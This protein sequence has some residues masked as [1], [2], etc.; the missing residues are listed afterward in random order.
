MLQGL[1]A[2]CEEE[3]IRAIILEQGDIGLDNVRIARDR[4]T[5][6]SRG[7]AFVRFL[8]LQSAQEFMRN[9][10]PSIK[11]GQSWARLAYSNNP[12]GRDQRKQGGSGFNGHPSDRPNWYPAPH[13]YNTYNPMEHQA[14]PMNVGTR[15]IG[16]VPN[17]MLII[18]D[19]PPM[20]NESHVWNSLKLLGP[21]KRVMMV[22]DR[23]SRISWGFCFAE[24]EDIK[25]ATS[26]LESTTTSPLRIQTKPVTIHYAHH[27]SFIPA[28]A[29][30]QWT[31]DF[32]SESQLAMYWDEQAFLS[33]YSELASGIPPERPV[34]KDTTARKVDELDAFYA[35]MG[36]VLKTEPAPGNSV[37]SASTL[38]S[39]PD[40]TTETPVQSSLPAP[41]LP[42]LP[43][44]AK[45]DKDQLAGIAAAQA[46]EQ[47]AKTEE[48]RKR[49]AAS[50]TSTVGIAGGG[51]KISK[52]L[53]KWSTKQVELQSG[54]SSAVT[55]GIEE[56][57]KQSPALQGQAP[58]PLTTTTST[59][60]ASSG[61]YDPDELLDLKLVACLLC[62]RRLKTIQDLRKHQSL[63]DLHKKNLQDPVA[64]SNALKKSRGGTES[65]STSSSPAK[66]APAPEKSEEEPKYR[67]R[68]AERRQIFG[69]PDFPSP[70]PSQNRHLGGGHQ[71]RGGSSSYGRYEDTIIPE[72]PTKD[73]IKE[74]NI[75][76]RLLKSMGWKEGQ[77]LGK[78]GAGITAPIEASGYS[79][80]VGIGAGLAR[81]P[82]SVQRGPLGNYAETV[83]DLARRRYEQSG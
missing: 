57:Q 33:Q 14:P 25:G 26:A 58:Q 38:T 32:Q 30:T 43:T 51:L 76:N 13:P 64:V 23:Q 47:L 52:Q 34:N 49:K 68:A 19:L 6:M 55:P 44:T 54:E 1:P 7:F 53:Q 71:G 4:Q 36:D 79:Q 39:Q 65:S 81:K 35:S 21:L 82:G 12:G 74:D 83:K 3:D 59:T 24:F 62:Q 10:A 61:S 16:Q 17:T 48:K 78:D 29:P 66:G 41:E 56:D 70:S 28:Y 50:M 45:M 9:W 77:G 46:A 2:S 20:I 18:V 27:G 31:I 11:I 15:D 8:S 75:G 37:F 42:A 60:E 69:Q 72:Q 80:G 22:K 67:D 63:S 40:P 5:G 73:G